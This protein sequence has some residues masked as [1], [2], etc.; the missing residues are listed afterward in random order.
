MMFGDMSEIPVTTDGAVGADDDLLQSWSA[1]YDLPVSGWDFGELKGEM[2][3]EVPPWSYTE[4]A[5]E[6]LRDANHVLDGGETLKTLAD[7]LPVDTIATEGWPPN[8]PVATEALAPVG[9]QVV[10]YDAE[11]NAPMPFGDGRFDLILNCH[12][13]YDATEV[14]RVL[15]PGG[16]F[17]TQ[18]VDG[19]NLAETQQ[20]FG[21]SS[22]YEHVRLVNFSQQARDAGLVIERSQEWAGTLTF[23][24]VSAMVRYFAK[25]PWEVPDDFSVDRY[26]ETLLDVHR[27][28]A[29][30]VFTQRR[31]LLIAHA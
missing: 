7:A 25:V 29:A 31:F 21:G 6:H 30:L 24:S 14:H 15:Q 18:Q 20:L 28:N 13:A 10:F 17:V 3:G 2:T 4:I 19:R 8:M 26:A 12:D 27:S 5:R 11:A 16:Y 23:H 1:R 22:D 9:I